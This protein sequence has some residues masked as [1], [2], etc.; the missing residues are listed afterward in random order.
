MNFGEIALS[1][2]A[3][4]VLGILAG[5]IN[6]C[7]T[8]A[9]VKRNGGDG[10]AAVTATNFA[11]MVVNFLVLALIFFTRE[12][13]PLNFYATLLSCALVLS[14]ANPLFVMRL[15]RQMQKEMDQKESDSAPKPD[16]ADEGGE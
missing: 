10:L 7:I 4:A 5:Y 11:R 9:A 1:I 14:A 2:A 6:M 12:H 16:A 3:G 8:R 13:V 15:T